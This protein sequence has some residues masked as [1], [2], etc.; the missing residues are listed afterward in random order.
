[1]YLQ[2]NDIKK[3]V[4]YSL[5]LADKD[6][7]KWIHSVYVR[8]YEVKD[9]KTYV[10]LEIIGCNDILYGSHLKVEL[11]SIIDYLYFD[12]GKDLDYYGEYSREIIESDLKADILDENYIEWCNQMECVNA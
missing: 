4:G 2:I 1:M 10:L 9:H 3:Y 11:S 6:K 12:D 8:G 7:S 5:K